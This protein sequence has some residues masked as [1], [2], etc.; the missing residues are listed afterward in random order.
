MK[1]YNIEYKIGSFGCI[2][3][4][5]EMDV[6]RSHPDFYKLLRLKADEIVEKEVKNYGDVDFIHTRD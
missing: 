3:I 5:V 2:N 1:I 4:D 6:D